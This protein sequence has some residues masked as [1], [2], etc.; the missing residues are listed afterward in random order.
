M[1]QFRLFAFDKKNHIVRG[2]ERECLEK[3][4]QLVALDILQRE[5]SHVERVEVWEAGQRLHQ[6]KR[7]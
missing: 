2:Y 6:I 5:A 3:D 1:H 7:A 4:I